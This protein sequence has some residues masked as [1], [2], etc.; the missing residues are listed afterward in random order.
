MQ[1]ECSS[2]GF[3]VAKHTTRW[4][5]QAAHIS[6]FQKPDVQTLFLPLLPQHVCLACSQW[7]RLGLWSGQYLGKRKKGP[8]NLIS[9][10]TLPGPAQVDK[11]VLYHRTQIHLSKM[12]MT[13]KA[14]GEEGGP[15]VLR[16][17]NTFHRHILARIPVHI[18][19][20]ERDEKSFGA[21]SYCLPCLPSI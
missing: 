15:S 20:T 7:G 18:S 9:Q 21:G 17:G 12:A 11:S 16:N 19:S 5:T 8:W 1:K 10:E 3:Y 4:R 13:G 6:L 14:C 2:H